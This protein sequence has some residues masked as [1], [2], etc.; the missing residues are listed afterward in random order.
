MRL[1]RDIN[2]GS[3]RRWGLPLGHNLAIGDVYSDA[4][5]EIATSDGDPATFGIQT[6]ALIR[7]QHLSGSTGGLGIA[8]CAAGGR[9]T[10]GHENCCQHNK[11]SLHGRESG[12]FQMTLSDTM[13]ESDRVSDQGLSSGNSRRS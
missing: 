7:C 3:A 5:V 1:A 9:D 10:Q 13:S 6:A 11:R 12:Q 8:G 4:L 2:A